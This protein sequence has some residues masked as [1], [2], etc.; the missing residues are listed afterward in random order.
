[1]F[2][3]TRG[4]GRGGRGRQRLRNDKWGADSKKIVFGPSGPQF[5]LKI[6]GNPGSLG[7]SPGSAS[8]NNNNNNN[9]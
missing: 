6:R 5:G 1:M 9:N 3:G 4:E 8:G 7:P 2:T